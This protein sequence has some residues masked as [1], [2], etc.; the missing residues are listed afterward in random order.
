MIARDSTRSGQRATLLR[1]GG[2]PHPPGG[3]KLRR[4]ALSKTRRTALARPDEGVRAY[5]SIVVTTSRTPEAVPFQNA[6]CWIPL[7][8][9]HQ[10]NFF[11]SVRLHELDL[12]Y[13]I[14]GGGDG[15]ANEIGGDRQ[16][17]VTAID[18]HA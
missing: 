8:F 15:E 16:L 1:N 12:D 11:Y 18:Q 2:C 3:A 4:L 9:L 6:T 13:F 10:Q 17:T 7:R 5:V 14:H